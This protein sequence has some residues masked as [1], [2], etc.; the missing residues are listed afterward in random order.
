MGSLTHGYR[1][2]PSRPLYAFVD[3]TS[4]K[5]HGASDRWTRALSLIAV[6]SNSPGG[7][8]RQHD[9]P[10]NHA[11]T[12]SLRASANS[13]LGLTMLLPNITGRPTVDDFQASQAVQKCVNGPALRNR[14]CNS[15]RVLSVSNTASPSLPTHFLR[16]SSVQSNGKFT[17][18]RNNRSSA[19]WLVMYFILNLTL[20]LHN[21]AVLVKL[22]YPYVLTATHSLCSTL[23]ALIMQR[24]GFYTAS[25][26]GLRENVLLFAFSTL[27]SLNVA[28]S[29]VSLKMVSVPVR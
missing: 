24:K 3:A 1:S 8:L 9:E 2:T 18:A 27:Y 17:E 13:G 21:K 5:D 28:V 26:L 4:G 10:D 15:P 19:M 20:T 23:G 11:Y 6:T 29:N 7:V 14:G 12:D 16:S 25:R 22:P